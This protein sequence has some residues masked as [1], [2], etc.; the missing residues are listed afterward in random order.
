MKQSAVSQAIKKSTKISGHLHQ[1]E[2]TYEKDAIFYEII[3]ELSGFI[4]FHQGLPVGKA[5]YHC[6]L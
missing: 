6:V 2:F 3:P 1:G 4:S 5:E